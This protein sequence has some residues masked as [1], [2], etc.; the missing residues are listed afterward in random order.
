[1]GRHRTGA[2]HTH[3]LLPPLEPALGIDGPS[4]GIQLPVAAFSAAAIGRGLHLKLPE[5]LP[6]QMVHDA[7]LRAE[8][9]QNDRRQKDPFPLAAAAK[10]SDE[11][12]DQSLGLFAD[13]DRPVCAR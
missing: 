6:P 3:N 10:D 9:R 1:M 5:E 7:A 12:A 8:E 4:L 13:D 11:S 2:R